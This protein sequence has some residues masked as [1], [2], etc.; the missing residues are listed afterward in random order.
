V[1]QALRKIHVPVVRWP[2]GCFADDYDWRDGIGPRQQRP[3]RVNTNWGGVEEP[4]SFGTHEPALEN[5][6]ISVGARRDG[7]QMQG[8]GRSEEHTCLVREHRASPTTP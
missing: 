8:G 7:L 6:G 4:N 5:F 3:R 1:L 2:G